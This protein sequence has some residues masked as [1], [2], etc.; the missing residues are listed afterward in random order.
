MGR[1]RAYIRRR[2][3]LGSL[4]VSTHQL[5]REV[6]GAAA[7]QSPSSQFYAEDR[8]HDD[9]KR[10]HLRLKSAMRE[11]SY[12]RDVFS[13]KRAGDERFSRLIL[14]ACDRLLCGRRDRS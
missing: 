3:D 10:D 14:R 7:N 1:G 5:S 8:V 13:D 9:T 11:L 4:S 6:K 2:T 12:E